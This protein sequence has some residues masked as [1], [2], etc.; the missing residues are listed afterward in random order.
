MKFVKK[1]FYIFNVK[2]QFIIYTDYKSI[3]KILNI[4][5]YNNIL[6]FYIN[7]LYLLN[8]YI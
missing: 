2:Y 3:I 8:I 7:K 5:Y 4:D 6:E 1:N